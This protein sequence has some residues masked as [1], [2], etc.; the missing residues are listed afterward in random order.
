MHDSNQPLDTPDTPDASAH[1]AIASPYAFPPFTAFAHAAADYAI[2]AWQRSVL[3]ADVMRERGNQYETHLNERT[4]NVLDFSVELIVDGRTLPRPVNYGLVRIVAPADLQAHH[5]P[6]E[7]HDPGRLRPFVVFDPRAGHG[8]GIGGFKRDS[9]IGAALRAGHP[10]YFVGFLPN[11]VPGQ[12]V[13]DVMRAEAAFLEKVIELHPGS[14]G[15][16]AV[17]GNC[18][19]GW[20]ILMTAAM[21]PD[22]FGPIIVAGAPVSYWAGWRGKNPM[23]YSGGMLGGSWLTALTGDLGGGR[24]DGAWLVQNFENLNPA[25]TLW[26]KNYNLYAR[27]DTEAPRYL[28]FEKYWGGHVFLNAVEMQYIVDNLFVGNRLSGGDIVLSDGVR[29]D[30]RNIRSPIVVFCSYGDNITPPPQALGWIT[31]LYHDDAELFGHKQTIVY[32]THDNIGHLGI[33]V[34]S[35]TGRKEHREFVSNID[36]IDLLPSGLYEAQMGAKTE[37]TPHAELVE[38]DH[39]LSISPRSIE[40]VRAIVQPDDESDRRFATAAYVSNL[41]LGLYRGFVQPW[42]RLCGTPWGA[43]LASRLHPLRVPYEAWSDRHPLASGVAQAAER[44]KET[45]E[46]A[47]VDN[48]FWQMQNAVSDSIVTSLNLYRDARDAAVEQIFETVYGSPWLQAL[49]GLAPQHGSAHAPSHD[50]NARH[51]PVAIEQQRLRETMSKGGLVEASIRALLFVRRTHG[52][53]D[54]RRFNQAR[55]M[56]GT[57]SD[58]GVLSFKQVIREQAELLR[59]DADAALD[60]LPGMLAGTAPAEIHQAARHIDKLSTTLP[61][62]DN[63]RADLARVLTIFES[64]SKTKKAPPDKVR[65]KV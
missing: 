10:C 62:D 3:F 7:E 47:A 16:P 18:Q 29:L 34:S 22:L 28:G 19:A 4:P 58:Q 23:R 51:V 30:L 39:V 11:P 40:D 55:A 2:D 12:T 53:A 38:G 36:L 44:V 48:P 64:A 52:V 8:P 13:E 32:A 61:L 9:E 54:E 17:I 15:K 59:L 43:E 33:F 46:P 31:D 21:R 49:A 41:N 5:D 14:P 6:V 1:P 57:L 20:Q 63:E 24:F 45:R 42:V 26:Q 35:S 60:A 27:I 25:N 37:A 65:Q 50:V 56:L